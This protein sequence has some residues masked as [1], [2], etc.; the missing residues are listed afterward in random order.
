MKS[1][2]SS[3]GAVRCQFFSMFEMLIYVSVLT[4]MSSFFLGYFHS[5]VRLNRQAVVRAHRY[6]MVKLI[7]KRWTT[8]IANG[9]ARWRLI[10]ETPT[11]G[12]TRIVPNERYV[13]INVPGRKD[14]RL[15]LPKT[16]TPSFS[17]E[18]EDTIT[19]V[20]L[21]LSFPRSKDFRRETIRVVGVQPHVGG[22][23]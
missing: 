11:D 2:H 17:I 22:E 21:T 14:E 23:K 19:R 10:G 6:H 18:T 12:T 5:S 7:R 3:S 20:I 13:A 1:S 15:P 8:C 16:C 4:A 9:T